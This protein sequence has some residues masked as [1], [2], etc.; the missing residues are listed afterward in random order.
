MPI[1]W[2]GCWLWTGGFHGNRPCIMDDA[3]KQKTRLASRVSYELHKG[4][5]PKGMCV[6]H[7]CD[8]PACVNPA[9]LWLGTTQ[10]NTADRDRK[11]RQWHPVGELQGGSK[12]TWEQVSEIR[13]STKSGKDLSAIY[14][15]SQG[16]I[17][18]VLNGNKW[19]VNQ[20]VRTHF[21][22]N[23][24]I[25]DEQASAIRLDT[26]SGRKIAEEYEVSQA[27]V[28]LIKRGRLRKCQ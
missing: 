9:H 15:V 8:I 22:R 27:L 14:S 19:R 23:K 25:T 26:R 20:Y 18:N 6:C 11:K 10:E 1:P 28:S 3:P 13:S 4:P 17:S 24:K 2:T 21:P 5:I 7:T 12:L 16:T